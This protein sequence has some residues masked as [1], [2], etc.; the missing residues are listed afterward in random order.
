[1]NNNLNFLVR[2]KVCFFV[3]GSTQGITLFVEDVK[4]EYIS[5]MEHETCDFYYIMRSKIIRFFIF[6]DNYKKEKNE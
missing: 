3:L 4:D 1:M 2:K 6:S 5:G